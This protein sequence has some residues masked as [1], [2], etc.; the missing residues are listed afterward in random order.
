MLKKIFFFCLELFKF[1]CALHLHVHVLEE[2]KRERKLEGESDRRDLYWLVA[3]EQMVTLTAPL[4][5]RVLREQLK[6]IAQKNKTKES[7]KGQGALYG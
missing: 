3:Q 4:L 5:S 6:Y 2:R 1:V 7:K